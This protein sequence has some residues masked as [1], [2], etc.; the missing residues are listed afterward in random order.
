MQLRSIS[1]TL[2]HNFACPYA[3]FLKYEGGIKEPYTK[4]LALGEAVHSALELGYTDE[5]WNSEIAEQIF[6]SEWKRIIE[7]HE[8]FISYPE[9]RKFEA[10]GIKM[11]SIHTKK[12]EKGLL[13]PRPTE[14]EHAFSLPFLDTNIKGKID[15][16]DDIEDG[17]YTIDDYKSG[18]KEPD[19][20]FLKHN[21]QFTLYAWA[22]FEQRGRLPKKLYW[23]HLR[24]GKRL[25]TT[26]TIEDIEELQ[27]MIGNVLM[28]TKNDVRYRVYHE[29]I[30]KWCNYQGEICDDRELESRIVNEGRLRERPSTSS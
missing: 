11:I 17:D 23:H 19:A 9:L 28:L 29:A 13:P 7:E 2:L 8:V 10:D 22:M 25:E 1:Y 20:W 3:V 16:V 4:H 15:R 21:L 18:G 26:R 5:G 14:I 6:V 27:R 30:C 24:N 12:I